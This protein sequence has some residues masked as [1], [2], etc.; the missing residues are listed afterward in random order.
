VIVSDIPANL[1]VIENEKNG[2]TFSA[3]NSDVLAKTVTLV[4]DNTELR[5]R[6]GRAARQT[7]EIHYSLDSTAERYISLYEDLLTDSG[8]LN[9]PF[10]HLNPTSKERT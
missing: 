7:I 5:E 4:L 10:L 2:L 3:G 9:E 8:Q 1:E 6:L